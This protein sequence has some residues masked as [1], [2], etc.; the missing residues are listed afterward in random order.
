MIAE[1]ILGQA[2]EENA[3]LVVMGGYGHSRLREMILGG[4]TRHMLERMRLPVLFAH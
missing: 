1:L 4:A 3:D 2:A